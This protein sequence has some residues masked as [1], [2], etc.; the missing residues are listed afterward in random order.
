MV[1]DNSLYTSWYF[2]RPMW[3][4]GRKTS[5]ETN[6]TSVYSCLCQRCSMVLI[7]IHPQQHIKF[8]T[9]IC[10]CKFFTGGEFMSRRIP[11]RF[12]S[13][14]SSKSCWNMFAGRRAAGHTLVFVA[15]HQAKTAF[16]KKESG[17]VCAVCYCLKIG[18]KYMNVS[19]DIQI[20]GWAILPVELS[21]YHVA[22]AAHV[23]CQFCGHVS[24]PRHYFF[25]QDVL[26]L[27]C[28]ISI[29]CLLR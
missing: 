16:P 6:V 18:W 3:Y 10:I 14:T 28:C 21:Q 24:S 4:F 13:R 22:N 17:L 23:F 5:K 8:E 29:Y 9:Y 12:C 26:C 15:S 2:V 27:V 20:I 7:W 19:K 25:C 11:P 1:P